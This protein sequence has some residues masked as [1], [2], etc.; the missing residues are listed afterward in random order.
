MGF[1]RELPDEKYD[2]KYGDFYLFKRLFGYIGK[3]RPKTFFI[4]IFWLIIQTSTNIAIPYFV[5]FVIQGAQNEIFDFLFYVKA[6]LVVVFY[7]ISWFAQFRAMHHS[8]IL[9]G[10]MI[11]KIRYDCFETLLRN[12][13]KFYDEHKSGKLVSRVTSDTDNVSQM[14]QITTS[15]IINIILFLK[16][17]INGS[18]LLQTTIS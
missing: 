16:Y 6:S 8:S 4:I 9:T 5:K 15:F 14:A 17:I 12:D 7:S 1:I 11:R 13:M 2:R 3:H 18:I 10:E